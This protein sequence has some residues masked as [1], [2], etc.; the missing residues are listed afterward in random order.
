MGRHT[1]NSSTLLGGRGKKVKSSRPSLAIHSKFQT[2]VGYV[3]LEVGQ[4]G[5]R[6]MFSGATMSSQPVLGGGTLE[7]EPQ[8]CP[9]PVSRADPLLPSLSVINYELL[10]SVRQF[11][12]EEGGFPGRLNAFICSVQQP[13]ETVNATSS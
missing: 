4:E 6:G 13:T 12:G 1:C 11:S 10:P 9:P 2:T 8:S 5:G 7:C 3:R